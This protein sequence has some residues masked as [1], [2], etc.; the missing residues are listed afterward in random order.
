MA[1]SNIPDNLIKFSLCDREAMEA[2]ESLYKGMMEGCLV[3]FVACA[4]DEEGRYHIYGG[5]IAN[6][7]EGIGMAHIC[8]NDYAADIDGE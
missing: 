3:K 4:M 7:A 2:V 8:A 6:E 5:N 1:K